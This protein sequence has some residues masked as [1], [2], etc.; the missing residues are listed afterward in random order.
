MS[1][2]GVNRDEPRAAELFERSCEAG[3]MSGCA[4]S[5][6]AYY[7]GTGVGKDLSRASKLFKQACDGG[8]EPACTHLRSMPSRP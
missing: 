8:S 2:T 4:N 7:K 1:G 5:G 3:D 6:V